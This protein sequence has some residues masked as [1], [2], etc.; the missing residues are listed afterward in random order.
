MGTAPGHACIAD[1]MLRVTLGLGA[2]PDSQTGGELAFRSVY[3]LAVWDLGISLK[4]LVVLR[5]EG[6][7]ED[8]HA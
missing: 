1:I 5:L 8:A 7:E 4:P 6:L 2:H 3:C